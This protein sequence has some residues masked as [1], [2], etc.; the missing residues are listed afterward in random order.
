MTYA[1]QGDQRYDCLLVLLL[2]IVPAVA[3]AATVTS[4]DAGDRLSVVYI[5]SQWAVV[6]G[7]GVWV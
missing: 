4:S 7:F 6:G 3:T 5:G 2:H 1:S